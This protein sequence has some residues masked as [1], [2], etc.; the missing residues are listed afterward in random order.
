V[1][2]HGRPG[3]LDAV[4]FGPLMDDVGELACSVVG[5]VYGQLVQRGDGLLETVLV[6]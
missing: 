1:L 5:F 3:E 6:D 2:L 4:L